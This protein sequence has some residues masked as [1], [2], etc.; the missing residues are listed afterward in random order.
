ME[1]ADFDNR[2]LRDP[3]TP[4]WWLVTLA[5]LN[6]LVLIAIAVYLIWKRA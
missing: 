5:V 1:K 4:L 2:T 3:T 6:L